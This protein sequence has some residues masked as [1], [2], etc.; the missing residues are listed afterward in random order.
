MS[1]NLP[2]RKALYANCGLKADSIQYK[3][4]NTG[5]K[6]NKPALKNPYDTALTALIL[7]TNVAYRMTLIFTLI[8]MLATLG[9][10]VYVV[11][12]YL[13]GNP[14]EGYTT[15]MLVMSGAFFALFAV[16]A[17]VVKYLSVIL[18]LIFNKQRYVIESIE[19][20]TG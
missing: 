12:V 10:A 9:S 19:K 3:S 20:I 2:Y 8:M 18:G 1:L 5:K 14:V 16:L 11:T 6:H 13:L 7:F 4:V 17:V 15:M